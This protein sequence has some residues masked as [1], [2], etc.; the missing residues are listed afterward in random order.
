VVVIARAVT[1]FIA[2]HLQ[3]SQPMVDFIGWA[4]EEDYLPVGFRQISN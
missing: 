3:A 2:V 1:K 4:V